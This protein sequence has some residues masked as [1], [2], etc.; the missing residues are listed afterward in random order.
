MPADEEAA[1]HHAHDVGK[2]LLQAQ[3][4]VRSIRDTLA[5]NR[6][7]SG[8]AHDVLL[9]SNSLQRVVEQVETELRLKAEAV[10]NTVVQSHVKTLPELGS[11]AFASSQPLDTVPQHAAQTSRH[12]H[13]SRGEKVQL[14]RSAGNAP[15]ETIVRPAA[16]AVA[17]NRAASA[18]SNPRSTVSR[19]HMSDRFGIS[20]PVAHKPLRPLGRGPTGRLNKARHMPCA[21]HL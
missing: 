10:L 19:R 8:T 11:N 9:A 17:A 18:I 20:E 4:D 5:G 2:I 7:G 12:L 6:G 15:A 16:V 13:P 14:P 3:S 21:Q 1:T